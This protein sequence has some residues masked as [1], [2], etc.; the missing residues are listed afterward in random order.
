MDEI[1]SQQPTP[2]SE[3][4]ARPQREPTVEQ[5]H[6]ASPDQV[7]FVGDQAEASVGEPA[8][9]DRV[10]PDAMAMDGKRASPMLPSC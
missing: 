6:R 3:G 8:R 9:G 5:A 10:A 7:S 1:D 4:P 2:R